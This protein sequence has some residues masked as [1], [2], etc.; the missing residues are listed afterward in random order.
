MILKLIFYFIIGAVL[1]VLGIIDFK[2]TQHNQA[3]KAA[4]VGLASEVI[5]FVVFYMIITTP[6]NIENPV[7]AIIEILAYCL[8]GAVGAYYMIKKGYKK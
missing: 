6:G 8:G 5:G 7:K 2:A 1:D 3:F 4:G